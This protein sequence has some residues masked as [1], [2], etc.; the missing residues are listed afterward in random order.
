MCRYDKGNGVVVLN[1]SDYF[2]KLDTIVLD[3]EKFQ[4][5]VVDLD[6]EHPVIRNENSIKRYL[7]NNVKKFVD[8]PH[9]IKLSLQEVSQE[10][11]MGFAKFTRPITP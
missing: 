3:E 2:E 4:K 11:F 7:S 10:N 5:I 6:L 1:N 8:N 9:L